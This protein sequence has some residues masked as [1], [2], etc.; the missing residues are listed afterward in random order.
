MAEP[1]TLRR[2]TR[3]ETRDHDRRIPPPSGD[4]AAAASSSAAGSTRV[5]TINQLCATALSPL[6][7]LLLLLAESRGALATS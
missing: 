5:W 7:Y 6:H 3:H 2:D 1:G 4:G